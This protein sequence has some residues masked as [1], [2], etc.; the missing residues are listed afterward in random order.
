MCSAS[1]ASFIGCWRRGSTSPRRHSK[2]GSCRPRICRPTSR[3][4]LPQPARRLAN[5]SSR[6]RRGPLPR[7]K[8]MNQMLRTRTDVAEQPA[9]QPALVH[10][11]AAAH[12][13]LKLGEILVARGKLD[14]TALERTLRVQQSNASAG[15]K[16]ERLGELLVT[17]GL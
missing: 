5:W 1:P 9:P 15:G 12:E 4:P 14:A 2:R 17:L 13:R 6:G 11:V 3:Q 10:E 16:R 8:T 7:S